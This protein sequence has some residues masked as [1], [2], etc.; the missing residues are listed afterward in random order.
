MNALEINYILN[1]MIQ[2]V[3]EA[4]YSLAVNGLIIDKKAN[5]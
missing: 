2:N 3:K 1:K 5:K 4:S